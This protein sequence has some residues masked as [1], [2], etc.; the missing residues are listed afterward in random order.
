MN[1]PNPESPNTIRFGNEFGIGNLIGIGILLGNEILIGILLAIGI[2]NSITI[3]ITFG[4]GIASHSR[5]EHDK[6]REG[7]QVMESRVFLKFVT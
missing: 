4:I 5:Y 2:A 6:V 7:D 1:L 3:E